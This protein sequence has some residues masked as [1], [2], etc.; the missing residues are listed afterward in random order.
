MQ[1]TNTTLFRIA[2]FKTNHLPAKAVTHSYLFHLPESL[3]ALPVV[4]LV[5]DSNHLWGPTGIMGFGPDYRNVEQH[6]LAW[7]KPVSVEWIKA[8]DHS[9]FQIDCGIRI[10]GSDYNREH[11]DAESKFSFRL[12]FRSDYG[13]GRLNYPLFP[14][15]SVTRFDGL[16]LRAGFNEQEN[17][18]IRD[19]LHR[20]LFGDMG[21]LT[22]HGN[23][24]IVL[25]N[26]NYY[27]NPDKPWLLPVYN[28]T[29]RV[30]AEFFQEHL[31][32]GENWDVVKPPWQEGGGAVDGTFANMQDLVNYVYNT[33][34]VSDPS[35]YNTIAAWLDLT[36]F[37][38]YLVLNT[39]A[40]MGDWP[41]NNWRAGR[42]QTAGGIWRFVVWDAEWGM[43]IYGRS[44]TSINSFTD[45]DAGLANNGSEIARLYRR[46]Q[47]SAEFRLL[48]AD[49]VQKHFYNGG[50]LTGAHITNRFQQLETELAT[51]IPDMNVSILEWV[52]DR[53]PTYV[54]QMTAEGLLSSVAAPNFNQHGGRVA[55][56]FNLTMSA[57]VGTIYFT[58]DGSDPRVPFTGAIAASALP[59]SGPIT[60]NN[61]VNIRMRARNGST[62]S[63]LTEATFTV[64]S[65][66]IPLRITELMYNPSGGSLYEFIELQNVS[67]VPVDLSGIYFDGI[68]FIFPAG[69]FLAGNAR[70]VLGANTDTNAWKL[71][72][73]G[74]NPV[75]WFSGSLNNGGER[76]SLFDKF[77]NLITS[78]D[79]S[80]ANGWPTAADGGGRSLEIINPLGNPDEPANW[81][82]SAVNHGTPGAAN[83]TPPA[84]PVRLNELMAE[85]N[86]A[87]NHAGTFPDWIE[88]HNPGA[89]PVNLT[90]WSL[91]DDGD[92]RK[93]VF[94]S[95]TIPAGGYLVVW[96]D[97]VTNTT[98]GLHTG[99]SLNRAGETVSLYDATTNR[100]DAISY[101]LQV[102]DFSVG[103]INDS[104]TLNNSTPGTANVATPLATTSA[105][106]INEWLANPFAGE[107]DWIELYNQS[108]N[109]PVSLQGI[110]L[111]TSNTVHQLT[112]LSFLAPLDYAQLFAT[113][114][115]GPDQLKFK[116][117]A[118]GETLTLANA[119]GETIETISFG[120][121]TEG[122]SAGRYPDGATTLTDFVGSASPRAANYLNTYSGPVL[123]EVL[124][125]NQSVSVGG[126][127]VDYVEIHN[128]TGVSFDLGG[129]SLS[130]D[131]PQP[132]EWIFPPSTI[133]APN[134]Y[135]LIKCDGTTPATTTPGNF[136]LGKSLSGES[137]GVY[138]FNANQ[139]LVNS[140][141][142]G[143]QVRDLPIG[144]S[145]GQWRLLS[146]ATAGAA[147]APAVALGDHFALRINEWMPLP[148][149]GADWFELYN[150]T[151]RPVDLSTIALSDDP[152]LAGRNKFRPAALSFIGANG[153]VQWMADN[154]PGQ[155]R[156]HVNF[157]LDAEG[158]SLLL[159]G[160]V[161]ETNFTLIDT[162]GFGAQA[163][164][165]S[166]GR[167][168]DGEANIVMFPN[169]ATPGT[170]NGSVLPDTD[171]DGIPDAAEDLM[172]LNYDNPLDAAL[173]NDVDG[174][175]N[176][177]EYLAGTNHED[178]NS[179]LKFSQIIVGANI[180]LSFEAVAGKSYSVLW[181]SALTEED[182]TKLAD[183]AADPTNGMKTVIDP[184]GG[185]SGRFYRLTTPVWEP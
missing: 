97:A 45:S 42:E 136:N 170:T 185:N 84:A 85:N 19:E 111:N 10:Q 128:P 173:D 1:I 12:Y 90:G 94:P 69:T 14:E 105:L 54:N 55:S 167:L 63:A 137:G 25:V 108:G 179:N 144:L 151:N 160:V 118:S 91:S 138:L 2:A 177:Q 174:M 115:T 35:D 4:S 72:Y 60:L 113:E 71:L 106:T 66:G 142:Y 44:P 18:F 140:V 88:L 77:G 22:A 53:W 155:G 184:S 48:W 49:R 16:V 30:H 110:Y 67:G 172:G 70:L 178:P 34:D 146:A 100:V 104:W 52:R 24:A 40:G 109:F 168:P 159:Y 180:T 161:N 176:L 39:Y 119:T 68:N 125:R 59:Y 87:V 89:S 5:T 162:L 102:A 58:T 150:V 86:S 11:S 157:A 112:A 129:M 26:G 36:N 38:D 62:W 169:A 98:P 120:P 82:A 158:E 147:N 152:S 153:Y 96:C 9:G 116:L 50:A 154:N 156:H 107:P 93:F 65:L 28:P 181:K 165:V 6:G 32:G 7:E 27:Y 122:V 141:E 183:V 83:S 61:T 57:P 135:L 37:V 148:I 171:G 139:Q 56:G 124:A 92:A 17:P 126:T 133:I 131:S 31:G 143:P 78:V 127:F 101:G 123:N 21:Q 121:Q 95:T 3:R 80:D 29:E 15:T 47:D 43:G 20:R 13:P 134:G 74:V 145:G 23:M 73:P 182:W 79:Y 33:A 103:R 164:N 81:Q 75:G 166:G 99:F 41:N 130:E 76:I 149:L 132:G 163:T 114:A 8:T 51:I 64:G 175:T 117:S 46:L